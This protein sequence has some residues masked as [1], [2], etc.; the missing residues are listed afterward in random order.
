MEIHRKTIE[1]R[2]WQVLIMKLFREDYLEWYHMISKQSFS[3]SSVNEVGSSSLLLESES[4]FFRDSL[5]CFLY[6]LMLETTANFACCLVLEQDLLCSNFA[7]RVIFEKPF[8]K[9]KL[10]EL[11]VVNKIWPPFYFDLFC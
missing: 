4:S 1:G 10:S 11:W 8:L 6:S 5:S 7:W 2:S 3:F 9:S